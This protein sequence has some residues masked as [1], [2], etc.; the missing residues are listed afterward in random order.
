M[1][2]LLTSGACVHGTH[3]DNQRTTSRVLWAAQACCG[4]A[5]VAP[6]PY[7]PAMHARPMHGHM[8]LRHSSD[9][10]LLHVAD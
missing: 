10:Q 2:A 3:E 7:A 9:Q 8:L 5:P 4:G 6:D 1:F